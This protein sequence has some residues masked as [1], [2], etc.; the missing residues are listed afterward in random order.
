MRN[1]WKSRVEKLYRLL[2]STF[3]I[4]PY[5]IHNPL[6]Y[7]IRPVSLKIQQYRKKKNQND[8]PSSSDQKLEDTFNEVTEFEI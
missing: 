4:F 7:Y 2:Q 5:N 1:R 8:L 3:I 6:V